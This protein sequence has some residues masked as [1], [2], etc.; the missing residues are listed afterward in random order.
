LHEHLDGVKVAD[1]VHGRIVGEL[2][3]VG[4]RKTSSKLSHSLGRELA[5]GD[6]LGVGHQVL[7]KELAARDLD[8]EIPLEAKDDVQK[9]D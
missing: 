2:R 1:A 6:P 7:W 8:P 5:V 3:K 4:E 9:I